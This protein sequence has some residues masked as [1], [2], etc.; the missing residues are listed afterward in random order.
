MNIAGI[1]T[2]PFGGGKFARRAIIA[3]AALVAIGAVA[4]RATP[5]LV[6][7][8]DSGQVLLQNEATDQWYPARSP[9]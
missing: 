7:D 2:M 9:S 3:L 1:A 8:A 5:Y 6:V 4:A